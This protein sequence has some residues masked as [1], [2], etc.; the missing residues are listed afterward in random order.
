MGLY[1]NPG[2]IGFATM[3]ESRYVDKTGLIAEVNRTLGTSE[4][5]TCISRPRRFGKSFAAKM[6]CAYYDRSCDSSKLFSDLAIA[7][8]P[9][10]A[11]HLNRYNVV[12]LDMTQMMQ[13][14]KKLGF[15][16]YL[17]KTIVSGLQQEFPEAGVQASDI[18]VDAMAKAVD[19]TGAR[20]VAIF[21][22]WDAP[23]RE[24]PEMEH[25]YIE[26]LR[27]LFKSSVTTDKVFSAAYLTGIFP[28]KKDKGQSAV[29]DF[30]EY[31]V[32]SPGLF[33]PYVG[34]TEDE[35]RTL[36]DE[37]GMDFAQMRS[38]Y[39]GYEF[40]TVRSVYNPYAVMRAVHARRYRSYWR[41]TSAADMLLT[42]I[43]LD[44]EGLQDDVVRLMA[45][46]EL[47]VNTSNFKNDPRL[48][49]DRDDALTLMVHL[50]Y[51]TFEE[52]F[53]GRGWARIPNFEIRDEFEK[54]LR[55]AKH[56]ELVRLVRASDELLEQTIAGNTQ[57][58]ADAVARVHDSNYAPKF[59]NDE[60]ALRHTVKMAYIS[61]VDQYARVEELPSGHG[62]ADVVF[63]PRRRS[64][65]PALV[66]ELKW[67]EEPEG[68]IAQI[69]N[70][71][72]AALPAELADEVLLVGISYDRKSKEHAC[73][74]EQVDV[75]R[76]AC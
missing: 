18:P 9:S 4:K 55:Q 36:C 37:S 52:D 13:Q 44:F 68:A 21:D 45:G 16:E 12:N 29:S 72:Y 59:Y 75:R 69:R 42:Y 19:A 38:W 50:G 11:R 76:Q 54:V 64:P 51:L 57:A 8:D 39:D 70:R 62:L 27:S 47:W 61:A 17:N 46:E 6:L 63:L 25:D 22:E 41:Q 3:R 56:P 32:L 67:N 20:F 23:I 24:T 2:N 34:F 73:T 1:I 31:S 74:I 60:Q 35:V 28:I 10:Y 48:I 15:V 14:R 66:V 40:D 30:Y 53:N 5:L 7:D 26:F 71:N 58:V 49:A 43:D 65:L 33:A